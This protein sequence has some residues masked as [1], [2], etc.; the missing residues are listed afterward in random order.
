MASEVDLANPNP[1]AR[2]TPQH[3]P[4]RHTRL[5]GATNSQPL[6]ADLVKDHPSRH[7][8]IYPKSTAR[9]QPQYNK[10]YLH[11]HANQNK[12]RN[13]QQ[14]ADTQRPQK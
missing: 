9:S 2:Y 4:S 6:L 8:N 14:C 13:K 1:R 12:T 3:L 5:Y 10:R 11:D 7:G